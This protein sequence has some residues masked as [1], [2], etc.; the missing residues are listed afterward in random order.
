MSHFTPP[1]LNRF[2]AL[3]QPSATYRVMDRVAARRAAGVQVISLCAGEPDVDTPEHVCEAGIAAIRAGYT[4][5]TQVAGLRSLRAAVAAKFQH[6]NGLSAAIN[7]YRGY[8]VS[9]QP[10]RFMPLSPVRRCLAK[11]PQPEPY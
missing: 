5:Y 2:L 1:Y 11:P 3:A 7:R 6:E 9:V 10:A 4:R 8:T